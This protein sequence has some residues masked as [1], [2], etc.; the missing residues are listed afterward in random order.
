MQ[1]E[2]K[3]YINSRLSYCL[4][5]LNSSE[6]NTNTYSEK[7]I[8]LQIEIASIIVGFSSI[9]FFAEE[10][11]DLEVKIALFVCV[12]LELTSL[13]FGLINHNCKRKFWHDLTDTVYR[14]SQIWLLAVN[15]KLNSECAEHAEKALA[16]PRASS[17]KWPWKFQ[18]TFLF[19][20]LVCLLGAMFLTI[21]V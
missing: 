18:T 6:A 11:L 16:S 15:G 12:I 5:K 14:T 4:D 9:G 13:M 10:A 21:E 17:P 1:D 7:F 3:D 2:N 20:G 19:L 8:S